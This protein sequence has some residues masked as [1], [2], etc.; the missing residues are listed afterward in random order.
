MCIRDSLGRDAST[1][2]VSPIGDDPADDVLVEWF[3]SAL[4]ADPVALSN[5]IALAPSRR[6]EVL[7]YL[8]GLRSDGAK[9]R[10]LTQVM[11]VLRGE[12]GRYMGRDWI[13]GR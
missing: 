11:R 6:K 1:R 8:S 12:P 2:T 3:Q 9:S 4:D 5:W 13:E 7:R 10:N